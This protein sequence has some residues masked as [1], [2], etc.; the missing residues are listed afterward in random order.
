M[1]GYDAG[2]IYR[3]WHEL[4]PQSKRATKKNSDDDSTS[5]IASLKAKLLK[6]N[7][8]FA[9]LFDKQTYS[10]FRRDIKLF[11]DRNRNKKANVNDWVALVRD[12]ADSIN[13][14]LSDLT[15]Q[16]NSLQAQI[17]SLSFVS[18]NDTLAGI[19]I[20]PEY[21]ISADGI[22]KIVGE[23]SI[24]ICRRPVIIT[25]KSF[26]V[27]AKNYKLTLAYMTTNGKWKKLPATEA[28]GI[29]DKNKLILL[30]N[31][32][33]PVTSVNA[34]NGNNLPLMYTVPRC[35]WYNFNGSDL[36]VDPRKKLSVTDE[37]ESFSVG[38]DSQSQFAN[39]LSKLL[40][41]IWAHPPSAPKR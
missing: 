32:D 29:F 16:R 18:D 39:T 8:A 15:S 6:V 28:A 27:E 19:I 9:R 26:D 10:N 37:S 13:S 4:H 30:S 23:S 34:L 1:G 31:K 35:G 24:T 17:K 11:G 7:K 22:K 36:F 40:P 38:G 2:E 21:S 33:L 25:G 3:E 14:R 41:Y 20:P 12:K 5:K